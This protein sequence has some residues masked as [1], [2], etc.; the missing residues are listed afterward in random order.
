MF[1]GSN[2]IS[3]DPKGRMAIPTRVREE[4]VASCGGRL[5]VTAHTQDRCLLVYPEP[6][7]LELLPQIEAL[8]SFNKVSQRTK[9]I[10]IGYATALEIDASGRVLVPPTLREYAN[11]D[12]KM[13]L[14]GQGKKLELWSEG[15]WL[16]LLDE[17]ADDEIPSEM[18]SLSL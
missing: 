11:L 6:E 2:S 1:T 17:P 13:M 10:L 5:V 7:W 15:S 12:K 14:V 3:M 4:L 9:R 8:P 16:A 18:L